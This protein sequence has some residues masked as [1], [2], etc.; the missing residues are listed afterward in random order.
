MFEE[1]PMIHHEFISSGDGLPAENTARGIMEENGKDAYELVAKADY[2][3]RG[4]V[5]VLAVFP[6][7][8]DAFRKQMHLQSFSHMYSMRDYFTSRQYAESYLLVLTDSGSGILEYRGRSYVLKKGDL[9]WIDCR[10][11]NSYRTEGQFWEHTDIHINGT[12][13]RP[14]YEEFEKYDDPV[15]HGSRISSFHAD[16]KTMLD[17]YIAPGVHR[18]LRTAHSLETMLVRLVT[19]G[20]ERNASH[21]AARLQRLVYYMH[22]HYS[23]PLTMND[24]SDLSGFSRYHLSREFRKLTGFPPIEYLIRLRLE[25]AKFLLAG[26]SL[27]VYKVAAMSGIE[28]EAYFSRLFHQRMKMT[29]AEYRRKN[30]Q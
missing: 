25:R 3:L 16:M 1:Y 22:E 14:L 9:F 30:A 20:E 18:T 7:P 15:L 28:N 24:L 13:I 2:R 10:I 26:T 23:E 17:E 12:G 29:P 6:M 27:P 8:D 5:D 4:Y 21:S 11:P 19:A